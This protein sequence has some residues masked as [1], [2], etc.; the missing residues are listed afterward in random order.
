MFVAGVFMIVIALAMVIGGVVIP[1][2]AAR[3]GLIGGGIGVGIAGLTLT[4]LGAPSRKEPLPPGHV[5]AR[6]TILDAAL[7][8]GA[9]AGY[10]MV[11]L[12]LEVRPKD[13]LPFQVK[14]KFSAGRLGRIEQGR[15]LE[16]AYDPADP[17][18]LELA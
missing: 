5:R 17:Q 8:P 12:T 11:E 15:T 10:Q 9:V 4:Y 7:T 18:K 3:P 1:V 6:A 13:G 16:V 2:D 14:R